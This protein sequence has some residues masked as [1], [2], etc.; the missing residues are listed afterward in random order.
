MQIV[1]K[2]PIFHRF[3]TTKS[4]IFFDLEKFG[5]WCNA[6]FCSFWR[7]LSRDIGLLWF[8][9]SSKNHGFSG[10][11]IFPENAKNRKLRKI[12]GFSSLVTF[13]FRIST[14]KLTKIDGQSLFTHILI[15]FFIF[16]TLGINW[17]RS[18]TVFPPIS[19]V[20]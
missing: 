9:R 1:G 4:P 15:F 8:W 20:L 11:A 10:L 7:A 3:F 2:F 13:R 16:K 6:F 14:L 12:C 19:A 17:L 18:T 5:L